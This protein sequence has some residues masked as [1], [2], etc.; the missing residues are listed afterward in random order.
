MFRIEDGRTRFY[1][2]DLN[3]RLV[4]EDPSISTVHFCNTTDECSL[5]CDSYIENGVNL[6]NVPNILL[7][8]TW[9]IRVYGYDKHYTKHYIVFNI[10]AR[11][12]PAD[13]VYTET[14]INTWDKLE[15]RVEDCEIT[16]TVLKEQAKDFIFAVSAQLLELEQELDNYLT[17]EDID[18]AGYQTADDVQAA[19][20]SSL[21]TIGIAEEGEY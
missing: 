19:I 18:K 6:V 2:W 14:E 8:D 5:V 1:Q 4:I 15:A 11:T 10:V 21:N 16:T 9:P 3:V 7:Q 17:K 20:D 12:K 13:Y